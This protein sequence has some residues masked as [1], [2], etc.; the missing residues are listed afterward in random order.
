VIRRYPEVVRIRIEALRVA[1]VGLIYI[2]NPALHFLV[3]RS[4]PGLELSDGQENRNERFVSLDRRA[5]LVGACCLDV[6]QAI[7]ETATAGLRA[8]K[9]PAL[10][11]RKCQSTVTENSLS[12]EST[13]ARGFLQAIEFG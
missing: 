4:N 8:G 7:S 2:N 3:Y 12:A 9:I 6:F 5:C 1:R 11:R 13:L 10:R